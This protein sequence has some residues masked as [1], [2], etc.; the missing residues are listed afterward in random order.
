MFIVEIILKN[1][2][3]LLILKNKR[4]GGRLAHRSQLRDEDGKRAVD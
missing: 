4:G 2:E 1:I 3:L